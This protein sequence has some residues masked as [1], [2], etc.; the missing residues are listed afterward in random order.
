MKIRFIEYDAYKHNDLL[1]DFKNDIGS[2]NDSILNYK[3]YG[4][5]NHKDIIHL[6]N[7]YAKIETETEILKSFIILNEKKKIIGVTVLDHCTYENKETTLCVFHIVVR[8]DEQ[9]K[10]YGKEIM[11]QIVFNG[12]Y[13]MGRPVNEVC[14][15]VNIKNKPSSKMMESIGLK[16]I[17]TD[18][19]YKIYS[20]FT[21]E[22]EIRG[23]DE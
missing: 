10:N 8:P 9:G 7:C 2:F 14:A 22:K 4:L 6:L 21:R 12:E 5:L 19:K 13:L 17:I 23:L 11:K 18:G 16:P 3:K 1:S 20:L 15:S